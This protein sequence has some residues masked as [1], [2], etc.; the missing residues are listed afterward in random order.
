MV[1]FAITMSGSG[2]GIR[3]DVFGVDGRM[4]SQKKPFICTKHP[5]NVFEIASFYIAEML[6]IYINTQT[7]YPGHLSHLHVADVLL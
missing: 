3:D 1:S 4:R 7:F 2:F 6:A 5:K